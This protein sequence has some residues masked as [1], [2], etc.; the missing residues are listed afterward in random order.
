M[1]RRGLL[2]LQYRLPE[3][4]LVDA[5]WLEQLGISASMRSRYVQQGWLH[6]P[7]HGVYRRPGPPLRWEQVVLSLQYLL[8]FPVA[9]AGLSAL[10][11]MGHQHHLNF[12]GRSTVHL[13]SPLPL[14]GWVSQLTSDGTF[15]RFDSN[16]LWPDFPP[17]VQAA[18]NLWAWE[19]REPEM[20]RGFR[21]VPWG[22]WEWPLLVS[23][24]ERAA[25]EMMGTLKDFDAANYDHL[26]RVSETLRLRPD[27]LQQWLSTCRSRKAVRLF[28][29]MAE[30]HH[31][32]CLAELDLAQLDWGRGHSYLVA[33][34]GAGRYC[35]TFDV[36]VPQELYWD[37]DGVN[38]TF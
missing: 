9:V 35:Q 17:Q 7:A 11:L 33:P 21:R 23:E 15:R 27:R 29:W 20:E 22:T 4:L 18:E 36:T 28:L 26:L 30:Y 37:R 24:E 1:S 25:V 38:T 8:D 2:E 10:H 13:V 12:G 31:L 32:P 14:P 5:P 19:W 16:R 3:G 34:G 6:R